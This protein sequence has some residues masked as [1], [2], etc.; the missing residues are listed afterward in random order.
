MDKRLLYPQNNSKA[1]DI[2]FVKEDRPYLQKHASGYHSEVQAYIEKAKPMEGLIQVLLTA[3]GAFPFWP[4]NV[5]GDRFLEKALSH[6]GEDYGYKTFLSNANYFT[7]HVNKDPALAKGKVLLSVWNE[8]AKRAELVVGIN[9]ALDPDA[10]TE[11]DAGRPLAFSMGAKLPYDVCS[12][13]ANKAKTR[14][15]Y[16]DHLRYQ[17]NQIHAE[18]GALIGALNPLPKFFDISR[19]LIPA[20]KTA[21]MW[22]KIASAA[23]PMS[24]LSSAFLAELPPGKLADIDFLTK[25]ASAIE[26]EGYVAREK[27]AA[28]MSKRANIAKKAEIRKQIPALAH[29]EFTERLQ[30]SVSLTKRALDA[31]APSIDMFELQK[32]GLAKILMTMLTLGMVPK[33]NEA[34][35]LVRL[36]APDVK[37]EPKL[38]DFSLALA[39]KLMPMMP[40]RS[41]LKPYLVRRVVV[42]ASKP[43]EVVKTAAPKEGFNPG[44]AAALLAAVGT[45]LYNKPGIGRLITEHPILSVALG[46]FAIRSMRLSG[47]PPSAATF[48]QVSLADPT[49]GFYNTDWQRRFAEMQARPVTVIKTGSQHGKTSEVSSDRETLLNYGFDGTSLMFALD[50]ISPQPAVEFIENNPYLFKGGALSKHASEVSSRVSELIS[51]ARRIVK[52]ASLDDLEFLSMIPE[53]DRSTVWDLAILS[54]ANKISPNDV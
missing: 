24:K 17:M 31:A 46:A 35:D 52:T 22:E 20:D 37:L 40:E 34:A 9:P 47:G 45:L 8:K 12:I 30:K 39:H 11:I 27:K 16:C 49:R 4:Q 51:S 50:G 54:A 2:F 13:C 26:Q 28:L 36:F 53:K 6:S 14:A 23:D 43:D 21:Y 3:L 44:L 19:V 38:S 42:L 29:P 41:F 33:E 25:A 32:Y 5:N 18:T 7:H 48:G 1:R 10:A 15:E